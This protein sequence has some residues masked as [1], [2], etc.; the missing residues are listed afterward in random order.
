MSKDRQEDVAEAKRLAMLSPN[1]RQAFLSML[2][3]VAAD[4]H[5]PEEDRHEARRRA[6][7]IVRLLKHKA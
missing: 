3:D 2:R 6:N 5:V 1:D 7:A 4:P